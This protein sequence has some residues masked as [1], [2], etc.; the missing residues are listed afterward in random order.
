MLIN[1]ACGQPINKAK[2]FA[3]VTG[4]KSKDRGEKY[5]PDNSITRWNRSD[6]IAGLRKRA[7][8]ELKVLLFA[9][10]KR[11]HFVTDSNTSEPMQWQ[12]LIRGQRL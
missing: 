5:E 1:D 3:F 10:E 7:S 8:F 6:H 2:S 9:K 12:R 11:K 4:L